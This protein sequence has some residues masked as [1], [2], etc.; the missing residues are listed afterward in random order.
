MNYDV[1]NWLHERGYSTKK[2]GSTLSVIDNSG[3]AFPLDTAAFTA[4][5]DGFSASPEAIR[6]SLSGSGASGPSGYTPLRNTL[7]GAGVSVGYDK[8][9]D[10]PIVN[11]QLLNKNDSRLLKVGDD[12]WIS[13]DYAESFIPKSYKNP[14]QDK[15]E[16]ILDSLAEMQFTYD[17]AS[18]ASLAAG[19]AQAM[20]AAKQAANSRG[21]LGGSTAEIMRQRAA[22]ELVPQYEQ[23]AY[24]R[25][26]E[27]RAAKMDTLSLLDDL[28]DG[29][30]AEYKTAQSLATDRARLANDVQVAADEKAYKDRLLA[31]SEA[32]A[33]TAADAG[34]FSR[35]LQKVLAMGR[36]D[37][38]AASV[39][40][41]AE[42]TLTAE[43]LQF[44]AKLEAEMQN[45]AATRDKEARDWE[46]EK[47][48]LR[49]SAD[50]KI[51]IANATK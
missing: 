45:A 33:K 11:G 35:Q 24:N 16:G 18:D 27:E 37:K 47:E 6:T 1:E 23:M 15:M 29:A 49:L 26:L 13:N 10:A 9:A 12:Y 30:F 34:A 28:A 7:S 48:L 38:E 2:D 42:G 21:L 31:T 36:V 8:T 51:R 22:A 3:K 14:Y 40:G 32:E 44:I 39:L 46:R 5:N 4:A 17:P 20:L 43:A 41:I 19:Q 50:E 25:F